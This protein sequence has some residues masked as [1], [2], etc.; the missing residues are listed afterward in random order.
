MQSINRVINRLHRSCDVDWPSIVSR[1]IDVALTDPTAVESINSRSYHDMRSWLSTDNRLF[2]SKFPLKISDF[3][4][5][6]A[7][8]FRPLSFR[9]RKI[10]APW[11]IKDGKYAHRK[12]KRT[13]VKHVLLYSATQ[14]I[15]W[16][17][18]HHPWSNLQR[19][20][21][22]RSRLMIASK[23]DRRP[24]RWYVGRVAEPQGDGVGR[25][26][27]TWARQGRMIWQIWTC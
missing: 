21:N 23:S 16:G 9:D 22:K 7:L 6:S 27:W 1:L 17:T 2:F 26:A 13:H 8:F 18:L 5:N 4:P 25:V 3:P 10:Y 15:F 19:W 20:R 14:D 11:H 24:P 12:Q